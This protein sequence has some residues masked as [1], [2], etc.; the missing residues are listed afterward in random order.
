[1]RE[2]SGQTARLAHNIGLGPAVCRTRGVVIGWA[3]LT[4]FVSAGIH[5]GT[6]RPSEL[7]DSIHISPRRS[8]DSYRL[9]RHDGGFRS[10]DCYSR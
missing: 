5:R 10:G 6:S 9:A 2:L 1:M 3:K 4:K 7:S 8:D